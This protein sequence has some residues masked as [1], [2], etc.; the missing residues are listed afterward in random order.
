MAISAYKDWFEATLRNF[1]NVVTKPDVVDKATM[2]K[3]MLKL[4]V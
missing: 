2:E 3:K 4:E 1:R